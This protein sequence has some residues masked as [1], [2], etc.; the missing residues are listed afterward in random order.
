MKRKPKK[1]DPNALCNLPG[2]A[3]RAYLLWRDQRRRCQCPGAT[4]FKNYGAKGI[5]V[6]YTAREFISWW[7]KHIKKFKGTRPSISRID[8]SKNYCFSNIKIEEWYLNTI[9]PGRRAIPRGSRPVK[10]LCKGKLTRYVNQISCAKALGIP[11]S[12]LSY[13]LKGNLPKKPPFIGMKFSR[14]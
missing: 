4:G 12:N 7:V 1:L 11:E 5:K 8:H 2:E 13:W 6:E 10:V 9:E 3:G 14:G